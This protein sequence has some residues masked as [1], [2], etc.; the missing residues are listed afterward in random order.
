MSFPFRQGRKEWPQKSHPLQI[1]VLSSRVVQLPG[2][3]SLGDP[4]YPPRNHSAGPVVLCALV[5]W[6]FATF[7]QVAVQKGPVGFRHRKLAWVLLVSLESEE[8]SR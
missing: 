4:R 3:Q 2:R 6:R 5:M 1:L 7:C 8:A